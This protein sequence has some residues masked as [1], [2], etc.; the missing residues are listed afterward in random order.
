MKKEFLFEIGVEEIPS[1]LIL[2][3]MKALE[4]LAGKMLKENRLDFEE[5]KTYGTPRRLILHIKKLADKQSE[6]SE[7]IIG[8]PKKISFDGEGNL[9]QTG[10]KFAQGQGV[11]IKDLF[12]KMTPKGEY[13]SAIRK[14]QALKTE[15]VLKNSL[16][17][18][19]HSMTFPKSMVWGPSKVRFV[20]PIRW[21][22]ALYGEKNIPFRFGEVKS[23]PLSYGHRFLGPKPFRV[24][25]FTAFEKQLRK[26]F[27]LIDSEDRKKIILK[28]AVQLGK[29]AGGKTEITEDMLDQ[30]VFLTEYPV[31]FKGGFDENFLKLPKEIIINAMC[32]HQGYFPVL[33]S[34][35]DRLLPSFVA[36]S[37]IKSPAANI[38]QKGN[39][40]V[41]R[42]RL[43]DAQFYFESDLKIKLSDRAEG[44]KKVVYQEKLGTLAERVERL[45]LLAGQI[46]VWISPDD[47]E[48]QGMARRAGK[49]SKADLLTGVVR[50]F[51]KLQGVIG[52][53]YALRQ[54][55]QAQIA[56]ALEEQYLPKFAGGPLPE[57]RLGKILSMTD[58]MDAIAGSFGVGLAPTGSEDPYGL[59]RQAAGLIHILLTFDPSPFYVDDLITCS[60]ARF[61]A[62]NKLNW[63]SSPND[64]KEPDL[65]R[66]IADFLR[67]RYA[68][69]LES[70]GYRFDIIQ[71]VISVE[72]RDLV[73]EQ[74]RIDALA[75][76]SQNPM[77]DSLFTAYKRMNN[78]IPK[79]YRAGEGVKA[80]LLTVEE[81]KKLFK[82]VS[83]NKG[84][85]DDLLKQHLYEKV[86]ELFADL[87]EPL[88]QFFTA[89]M[90][91]DPDQAV[92][93]NRLALVCDCLDFF[94]SYADF[95][96]ITTE[97]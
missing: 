25:S 8:P 9:S 78:I 3:G 18:L 24:K 32:E 58:K 48:F 15:I 94:R 47:A 70:K 11:P 45:S 13:L 83:E 7:E 17:G 81:E 51:P 16:P 61:Q 54:G 66:Q 42:S 1:N 21:I 62:Q 64:Q 91:N 90:V 56:Q 41:L 5:M 12:V 22:M 68:F 72:F 50:E 95:S 65:S 55:E 97:V 93:E 74:K 34:G 35:G 85:K 79:G 28:N 2:Y 63:T 29:S 38:I 36:V 26:Q 30:A 33:S 69:I 40:R 60:I 88:D 82:I 96:K 89:V 86:L 57:S 52:K 80:G 23:A 20:R 76:Y 14:K 71:S 67:Q 39:E 73:L 75:K 92:R 59:R 84:L 10:I 46:A 49:L 27:V 37:N 19:I 6:F 53:E 87:R 4:N 43:S 77:F 44:L 31:V